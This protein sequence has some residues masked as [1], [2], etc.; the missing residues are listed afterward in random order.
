MI[1][2][3]PDE[4]SI[5]INKNNYI[6]LKKLYKYI[7]K[8]LF[9]ELLDNDEFEKLSSMI[10]NV[11]KAKHKNI[12]INQE[13][14][15]KS[16]KSLTKSG[17]GYKKFSYKEK[18]YYWTG[19]RWIDENY[20]VVPLAITEKLNPLLE[21]ELS[22]EDKDV[23]NVYQ[24]VKRAKYAKNNEQFERAEKLAEKI[25]DMEPENL[26][27]YAVLCSSLRR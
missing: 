20:M 9:E 5:Q 2:N 18:N 11:I 26:S 25:L 6:S 22:K 7:S 14:L 17:N 12:A 10:E 24:L 15:V 8:K 3:N 4:K 13:L 23:E 1:E 16:I 27:A 19:K 21:Q